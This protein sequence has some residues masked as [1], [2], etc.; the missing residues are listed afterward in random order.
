MGNKVDTEEIKMPKQDS[1]CTVWHESAIV[2]R[3]EFG[4]MRGIPWSIIS[5]PTLTWQNPLA[6]ACIDGYNRFNHAVYCGIN[7][8]NEAV[9][10]IYK[11]V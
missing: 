4:N 11:G 2:V 3:D 8:S 1:Y 7:D 5:S 10:E 9:F 6:V